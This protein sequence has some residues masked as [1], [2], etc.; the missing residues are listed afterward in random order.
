MS[1]INTPDTPAL[2]VEGDLVGYP[3]SILESI[4]ARVRIFFSH[5]EIVDEH[6]ALCDLI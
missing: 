1:D 6:I 5:L 3:L 2:K 4:P